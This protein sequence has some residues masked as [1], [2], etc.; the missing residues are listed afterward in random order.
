MGLRRLDHAA[1]QRI[2]RRGFGPA[3]GEPGEPELQLVLKFQTSPPVQHPERATGGRDC[4]DGSI[5][6]LDVELGRL[7]VGL[8]EIGDLRD[9]FANL[10]FCLLEQTW[11]NRFFR[12]G[13]SGCWEPASESP[14]QPP[15]DR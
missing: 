11:V 14:S 8:G 7:D 10:I 1:K 13:G 12:H 3:V 9:E 15:P 4:G 6:E 5:Q 2:V